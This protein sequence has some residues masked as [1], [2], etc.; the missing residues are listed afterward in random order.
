V[1]IA[2]LVAAL[3]PALGY[4]AAVQS[5]L[6][7]VRVKGT[8]ADGTAYNLVKPEP[9][10]GI[11][12]VDLDSN[13]LDADYSKWLYARGIARAGTSRN[14]TQWHID[15]AVDNQAEVLGVFTA[16]FGAP[17][18]SIIWGTSLGG[19]VAAG[20]AQK[21]P[22][23][24]AGALP[25]CGALAGSLSFWNT[26]LDMAFTLK[27]LLA[28]GSSLPIVNVPKDVKRATEQW[29]KVVADAQATPQGR[30][31]IAL[32][33]AVGQVPAWTNKDMAEPKDEDAEAREEA[34]FR[35]IHGGLLGQMLSS[36]VQYEEASGGVAAWN[37]GVSYAHLLEKAYAV[38][39]HTVS[40]LYRK[41]G[42]DLKADLRTL[43]AAPRIAANP[44][45]VEQAKKNVVFD[46]KL[47]IP[48]LALN[49]TGDSLAWSVYDTAY[50]AIVGREGKSDLLR[51][52]HVHGP[53]HCGFTGAERIATFETMI[54]RL[55]T[56]RWPDTQPAALNARATAAASGA[57]RF[58]DF[59]PPTLNRMFFA[60]DSLPRT[61]R[62]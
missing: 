23:R 42:L 53:G 44:A 24:F 5:Q 48:V 26:R 40:E 2:L 32:A 8:L 35:T 21:Y 58:V 1:S 54:E 20:V 34:S 47:R 27:T 46:G 10:N 55:D 6:D 37:I 62:R 4:V 31:R 49:I 19:L 3:G 60:N 18:R 41:A 15:K 29:L 43:D 9:W 59:R 39:R 61:S 17:K 56:G 50:E 52:T 14:I 12:F 57:A 11:V 45:A 16:K 30:A 33:A 28:P 7:P 36:G 38:D 22:D 13:G 51:M 25:H